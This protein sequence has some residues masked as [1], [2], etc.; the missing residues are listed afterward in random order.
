MPTEARNAV[1]SEQ[2]FDSVE[3]MVDV[4]SGGDSFAVCVKQRLRA[5]QVVTKLQ[6][7]RVAKGIPQSRIAQELG[8]SPRRIAIIENDD[9]A[10][11]K[12]AELE[13]YARALDCVVHIGFAKRESIFADK[14]ILST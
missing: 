2:N 5:N 12:F 11:L 3:E 7:M 1:M 10:A 4:L 8:C 14:P 13:G 6:A 9:D